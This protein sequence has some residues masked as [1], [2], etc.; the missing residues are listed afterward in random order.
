M[1]WDE[2]EAGSEGVRW[3]VPVPGRGTAAPVVAGDAIYLLAAVDTGEVDPSK[4]RP[5]DQP[6]RVFGI[7]FPNTTHR[8]LALAYDRET[9]AERWRCRLA[10]KVPHEGV[11]GDTTFAAASPVFR[12]RGSVLLLRVGRAVRPVAGGGGEVGATAR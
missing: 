11:H 5:E 9:G 6:D 12:R 1:R 2:G 7:K 8:F 4:L 10:E 3:K